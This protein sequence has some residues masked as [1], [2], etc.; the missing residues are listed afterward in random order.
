MLAAD[1]RSFDGS[2]RLMTKRVL[3]DNV[4]HALLR[5][6]DGAAGEYLCTNQALVVPQEFE[7]LQREYPILFRR[8]ADGEFQSVAI[9]GFERGE[10]LFVSGGEWIAHYVPATL[11]RGPLFL[12]AGDDERP[13]GPAI[14]I[15]LDD[16]RVSEASGEPLFLP[17]GGAAPFLQQAAEAL[18]TVHEGLEQARA[19]FSLFA[20]LKLLA[21]V[22]IDVDLGD[23]TRC[24]LADYATIDAAGF[25]A[26]PGAAL[27]RLNRA[28]FLA[29]AI[30][31]RASLANM[32]R[33][34]ELKARRRAVADG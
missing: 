21:P 18:R 28:G 25:A 13:G 4:D 10:N 15:E 5:V 8:D 29:A 24:W 31:A 2:P 11:R 19:M 20:E 1:A 30:H 6:S 26:L 9:L 22:E 3:L 7:Q 32:N 23:G 14:A 33:L 27:K 34:I 16:P 17:H 12:A